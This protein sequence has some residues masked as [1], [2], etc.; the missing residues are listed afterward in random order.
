SQSSEMYRMLFLPL[1]S[2]LS[3]VSKLIVVPDGRLAYLPFETLVRPASV[4]GVDEYL[5]KRYVISYIPSTSALAAMKDRSAEMPSPPRDILAFGDPVYSSKS[6]GGRRSRSYETL[7]YYST[8]GFDFPRLPYSR[9]EIRVIGSLYPASMKLYLGKEASELNLKHEKLSFY[10]Y[11]HFAT[12]G[13]FDE[14]NPARSGIVLSLNQAGSEDGVLQINEIMRLRMNAD[15]VTLSACKT[16]LGKLVKGEG[17]TGM[18]RAFFYA[19]AR[20]VMA[21]LWEVNDAAT[22]ELMKRVYKNLHDGKN[23]SNA[24]REA[25]LWMI[26][27]G[28]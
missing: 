15:M 14:E 21:S 2:A 7:D 22:G 10:R 12:H 25:K 27:H 19:G 17:I 8:R 4:S 6:A 3:A 20:S 26:N 16:G 24:L 9:E 28:Q 5:L 23:K 11:I 1:E 18:T 13:Y